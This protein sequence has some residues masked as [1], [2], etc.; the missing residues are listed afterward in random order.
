MS[1]ILL[2]FL[3]GLGL[4][5]EEESNPFFYRQFEFINS[6]FTSK[7][8][9]NN[10][11][12][13]NNSAWISSCDALLN[14]PGIPQSGTGQTSIFC[15]F[16]ASE[17][18]GKHFGPYPY[19]LLLPE[20]EQKN[21]FTSLREKHLKV[22]FANAYPKAFFDYI[23]SGRRIINFTAHMAQ[24]SGVRLNDENDLKN[25]NAISAELTNFRWRSKLNI[26]VPEIS[27][28]DAAFRLL[29]IAEVNDFTLFEYFYLD[30]LGHGRLKESEDR[31]TTEL[32]E[33]LNVI[34]HNISPNLSIL[35]CSDHGNYEDR[36]IKTHTLNPAFLLSKG[37][38]SQHFVDNIR[39]LPDI[40]HTIMET[41]E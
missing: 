12:L 23:S 17:F 3:D 29:D 35:I 21:I 6:H 2:I 1:K 37:R 33:F 38:Y 7:P 18:I 14:M 32:D 41:F 26:D 34:L 36:S 31:L 5:R 40:Y 4:G 19:S 39:S 8:S 16:N 24:F 27:P 22:N 10:N 13:N 15:G 25:G 11:L 28:S 20:I 9:V 30:Y